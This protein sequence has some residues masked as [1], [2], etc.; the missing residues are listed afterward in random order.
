MQKWWSPLGIYGQLKARCPAYE[1]LFRVPFNI[2][3]LTISKE[4]ALPINAKM[5]PPFLNPLA[6]QATTYLHGLSLAIQQ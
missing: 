6:Y 1:V 4:T 3:P 5:G 2:S